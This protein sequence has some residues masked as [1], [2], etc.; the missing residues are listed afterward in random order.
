MNVSFSDK[1][2]CYRYQHSIITLLDNLSTQFTTTRPAYAQKAENESIQTK[3][4]DVRKHKEYYIK[5]EI[6]FYNIG[7]NSNL[8][9]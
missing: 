6:F 9:K 8:L 3:L 1:E 2:A 7:Q 4:C 5:K